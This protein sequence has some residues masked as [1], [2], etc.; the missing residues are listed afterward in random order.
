[1]EEKGVTTIF[2]G[3]FIG[4]SINGNV[5]NNFSSDFEK[6]KT[7]LQEIKNQLETDTKSYEEIVAIEKKTDQKSFLNAVS[8]F[9][10]QFGYPALLTLIEVF[11]KKYL[12]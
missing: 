10:A 1:M 3:T 11:L 2:G 4:G 8:K 5:S 12:T 6:I 9:A 7:E